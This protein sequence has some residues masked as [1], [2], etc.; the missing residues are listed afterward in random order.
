MGRK[1]SGVTD[2]KAASSRMGMSGTKERVK[3]LK[4]F[5]GTRSIQHTPP[6][7]TGLIKN[8]ESN[9]LLPRPAEQRRGFLM[10]RGGILILVCHRQQCGLIE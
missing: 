1:Q 3:A 8:Q 6:S 10:E 2:R 5:T 4:G 9:L 7:M